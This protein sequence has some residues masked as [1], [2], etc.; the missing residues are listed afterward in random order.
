M[1][2]QA[3]PVIVDAYVILTVSAP[4]RKS[5]KGPL[6]P[7]GGFAPHLTPL[8]LDGHETVTIDAPMTARYMPLPG[9]YYVIQED[10]YAYVNPKAVFERKYSPVEEEREVSSR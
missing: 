3:N 6:R 4:A 5:A 1:K 9:D 8:V 10:G 7:N 2:Y